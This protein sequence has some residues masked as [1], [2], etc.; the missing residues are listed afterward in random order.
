MSQGVTTGTNQSLQQGSSREGNEEGTRAEHKLRN[1][2]TSSMGSLSEGA[3][4]KPTLLRGV[5]DF[6]TATAVSRRSPHL[7]DRNRKVPLQ[8]LI[9]AGDN[10]ACQS[11]VKIEEYRR[12]QIQR[13]TVLVPR[14]QRQHEGS[15]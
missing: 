11:P 1:R 10:L 4:P 6:P 12:F 14:H 3:L 8:G 9:V 15:I 5:T 7:E 2:T 13:Q